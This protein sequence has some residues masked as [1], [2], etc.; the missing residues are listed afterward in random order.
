MPGRA[1][2]V[3]AGLLLVAA[4]RPSRAAQPPQAAAATPLAAASH[5]PQAAAA[6]PQAAA[7]APQAAAQAPQAA[8]QAPQAAP[9]LSGI[10]GPRFVKSLA[11]DPPMLPA[12]RAKYE[13]MSGEDDP[14]NTCMPPGLP[15]LMNLNFPF[16]ILQKGDTVYILF[17]YA[18]HQRRIYLNAEHPK[19]LDPTYLGHSVGH[20]EGRT[21]VV[22]TIGFTDKTWLDMAG[23]LHSDALHLVERFTRSQDG[24][25][26][27]YDVTIDDPAM[28]SKPWSAP[29][30]T[31]RLRNDMKIQE[32][33]CER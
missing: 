22:D 27:T 12:T 8:A 33:V 30:K 26:L 23:H 28:Y 32:F 3:C 2:A 14:L 19:D 18:Q 6:T 20:F 9:D 4:G 7:Q 25:T 21:L 29:T 31:H 5:P 1:A 11:D 10:W 24:Q 16:E 15:R 17:E 13:S